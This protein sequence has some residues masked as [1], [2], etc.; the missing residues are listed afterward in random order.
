MSYSF[1]FYFFIIF[2]GMIIYIRCP[3]ILFIYW[4]SVPAFVVPLFFYLFHPTYS[5]NDTFYTFYFGSSQPLL[6]LLI[7]IMFIEYLKYKRLYIHL[8]YIPLLALT[9]FFIVQNIVSG[10]NVSPLISNIKFIIYMIIPTLLL[11]MSPRI[12]PKQNLFIRFLIAYI[13][14]Q[15]IFCLFNKA[16]IRLYSNFTDESTF[17]D[18]YFC[19]TF[20]RYNHLT[21]YLTTFFLILSIVYYVYST[22]SRKIYIGISVILG[23]IILMSGARMSVVLFFM[24]IGLCLFLFR[25]K[26]LVLLTIMFIIFLY[27]AMTLSSK[28]NIGNQNADQGTGLERNVT[29]LTELFTSKDIDEST[30]ALSSVLFLTKFNNPILGNGFAFR[31]TS[32][33]DFSDTLNESTIKTDAC[34]AYMIV[35]YGIVGILCFTF[36]F[37]TIFKKLIIQ[38]QLFDKRVWTIVILYYILFSFTETGLFDIMQFSMISVFCFCVNDGVDLR[39]KRQN[40][41]TLL[42]KHI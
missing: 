25:R 12:R 32:E 5:G 37:Y 40:P 22:I 8:F 21:N 6:Y 4:F 36:L 42:I 1:I 15:T 11:Y 18:E 3:Q 16:G 34:L 30:L 20:L 19:G 2:C 39:K 27:G 10:F 24:T 33:Y 14:I 29:G 28:F 13:I 7:I 26:N 17:S 9:I 38:S 23:F 35:E 31:E 41:A